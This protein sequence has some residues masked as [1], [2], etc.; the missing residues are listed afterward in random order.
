MS[1]PGVA[2][3]QDP[4]RFLS[5]NYCDLVLFFPLAADLNRGAL[6][7]ICTWWRT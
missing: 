2:R 7:T 4:V 1:D 3:P 6:G 5:E